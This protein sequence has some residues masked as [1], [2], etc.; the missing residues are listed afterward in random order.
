MGL[1]L[2]LTVTIDPEARRKASLFIVEDAVGEV[3][4]ILSR[5]LAPNERSRD[6]S[7]CFNLFARLGELKLTRWHRVLDS[8]DISALRETVARLE[9]RV[10]ALLS[11]GKTA[12]EPCLVEG[13]LQSVSTIEQARLEV[14]EELAIGGL[15]DRLT[16]Y[17]FESSLMMP[18]DSLGYAL[19]MLNVTKLHLPIGTKRRVEKLFR[20]LKLTVSK[21]MERFKE[22]RDW[23][24]VVD[25]DVYPASFWWRRTG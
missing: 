21:A 5:L 16:S 9:S 13:V 19:Q 22:V 11:G 3:D 1:T 24:P 4:E 23:V 2:R 8:T 6:N 20:V 7:D 17:E 12:V 15:G 18:L 14:E 10:A 25:P